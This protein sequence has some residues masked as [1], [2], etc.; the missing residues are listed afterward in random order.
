MV[1]PDA[2]K[3]LPDVILDKDSKEL[4]VNS[5]LAEYDA[6]R[7][8]IDWLIR[9]ANQYQNFAIVLIGV[10]VGAFSW[11]L[12]KTPSLMLPTLLIIPLV[13]CLLGFLFYRQHEEVY[14]VA[15][16]L[17]DY[18]RPHLRMLIGDN[19]IWEWEEFKSRNKAQIK[20]NRFTSLSTNTLVLILRSSLFLLPSIVALLIVIGEVITCGFPYYMNMYGMLVFWVL[21]FG[22]MA[23]AV[24]IFL[25]IGFLLA[26]GNLST[27]ILNMGD[28]SCNN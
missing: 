1:E 9:D 11:I 27:R 28:Q 10:L 17:H 16:Y 6:L 12:D 25:F 5:W 13:F 24:F 3:S 20:G 19:S 23:D 18:I 4:I 8:E 22:F 2:F 7:N 15:A 14:I 21:S 26:R